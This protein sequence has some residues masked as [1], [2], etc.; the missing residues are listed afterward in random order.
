MDF[1][2]R[3]PE[4]IPLKRIDAVTVT[5]AMVS[6]YT[7]FGIPA[8]ILTDNGS[9]F[10][11]ALQTQLCKMLGI[12]PIKISPHNPRSNGMLER[13][14][15]VLK[16]TIVKS[17]NIKEWEK[18]VPLALFASR[19]TPHTSTGLSLFEVMFGRHIRGP[20]TILKELWHSPRKISKSLLQYLQ[21]LRAM[22]KTTK[23]TT[24][25]EEQAKQKAK[26]YYD[27]RAREDTLEPG[28][29]VLVL[30][31]AGPKG[32]STQWLGPYTVEEQLSPVSY[33]L[34]T[35]GKKAQVMH[36]NHLKRFVR[37]Y[38]VNLVVLAEEGEEFEGRL[39]L[40]D[41]LQPDSPTAALQQG[42]WMEDSLPDEESS[43]LWYLLERHKHIFGTNP[44]RTD[45]AI[46]HIDTGQ[47]KLVIIRPYRIPMRW[48]T[49]LEQEIKTLLD[50]KI[51]CQSSSP[52]SSPVVC[53][54]KP[55]GSIHMC[56]DFRALNAMTLQDNY[57]STR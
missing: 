12:S 5:E 13:W 3:F 45:K 39:Q 2:S 41:P 9:C 6:T 8:E 21:D 22:E 54:R 34:A 46:F 49:Q 11:N 30:H 32:I 7:R 47:N 50:L 57:P 35:P 27:L 26:T 17:G 4:T 25:L 56:V 43:K 51:I 29:E 48:K 23:V 16:T 33:R 52:W 19:D 24:Q 28:E 1:T 53:V 38:P 20:T 40:C 31:P 36:R 42:E 14:H 10:I 18:I 44:G 55:D 37:D 15:R